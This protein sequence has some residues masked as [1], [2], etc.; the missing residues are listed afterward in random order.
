MPAPVSHA[1]WTER[2]CCYFF[3][4]HMHAHTLT[5][6]DELLIGQIA[7]ANSAWIS[8]RLNNMGIA[9]SGHSTVGDTRDAIRGALVRID[10]ALIIVTGGLGPTKDDITKSV[11]TEWVGDELAFHEET[12]QRIERYFERTGRKTPL[13]MRGQAMLP[14]RAVIMPNKMGTAP[15]MWFEHGDR[16]LISLPG[17]PFE[18]QHLMTEQ[19]EPRLRQR[20][21]LRPIAHRTL[22][23][24]C[25]G[26]TAVAERIADWEDALPSHLKLAYLPGLGELKLRLSGYGAP[27]EGADAQ[28]ALEREVEDQIARLRLRIDDI[29]YG[30]EDERLE[31]VV[32]RM[33]LEQNR[34]LC[35]A[36]SCTGGYIAHLITSI[37][38]S[39]RYFPGSIVAYSYDLKQ[40]LLGVAPKTLAQYGAVSEQTVCEMARGALDRTGADV[41][42][43]VSGI[44][45]PDGGTPDKPVG[46]VW[47]AVADQ[48]NIVSVKHIFGRDRAKNIYMT[49]IYALEMTRK[50]LAKQSADAS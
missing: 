37:P 11:L 16:V 7:D 43:A 20:F 47:M 8:R 48:E 49:A 35:T 45:G 42:I 29:V 19:V 3:A 18:M 39:S 6:G 10:A 32:G 2:K 9:V 30:T 21:A 31:E 24:A 14:S 41:A 5:I 38:G 34:Q 13:A 23:T 33:L 15:G 28:A 44:A 17:V 12:Y 26:E 25:V 4:N 50:F 46:T 22:R 27:G 36:E 1:L 40:T